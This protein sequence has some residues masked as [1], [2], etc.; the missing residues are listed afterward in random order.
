MKFNEIYNMDCIDGMKLIPDKS[1][2]CIITSPPY[3]VGLDYDNKTNI[4]IECQGIQHFVPLKIFGG[5][6][7]YNKNILRDKLKYDL[8]EKHNVE[9]VYYFPEEFLK[10][11]NHFY[12]D[13]TCFHTIDDLI[14]Y[15]KNKK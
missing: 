15:I 7:E 2:N 12:D 3:N 5:V 14:N 13:K 8:C 4:G 1:I 11:E 9:I 6:E 10:Y